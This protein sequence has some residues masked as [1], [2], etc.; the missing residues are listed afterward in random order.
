MLAG[1][2]GELARRRCAQRTRAELISYQP[3]RPL[4]FRDALRISGMY[5]RCE[6]CRACPKVLATLA[7]MAPP[8]VIPDESATG[9]R[10]LPLAS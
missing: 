5:A 3:K 4:P 9:A 8:G 6:T 2:P 10:V 7:A 1:Y